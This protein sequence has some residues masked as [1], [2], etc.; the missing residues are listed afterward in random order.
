VREPEADESGPEDVGKLRKQ[1]RVVKRGYAPPDVSSELTLDTPSSTVT[2]LPVRGF[3]VDV[4]RNRQAAFRSGGYISPNAASDLQNALK[5]PTVVETVDSKGRKVVEVMASFEEGSPV[6]LTGSG[7]VGKFRLAK[8]LWE[9]LQAQRSLTVAEFKVFMGYVNAYPK[10]FAQSAVFANWGNPWISVLVTLAEEDAWNYVVSRAY[11]DALLGFAGFLWQRYIDGM[12]VAV[13]SSHFVQSWWR[14]L[15][16]NW[17]GRLMRPVPKVGVGNNIAQSEAFKIRLYDI[18][19][20]FSHALTTMQRLGVHSVG[21]T[22][23]LQRILP[24]HQRAPNKIHRLVE[25][26][27]AEALDVNYRMDDRWAFDK[28]KLLGRTD[29]GHRRGSSSGSIE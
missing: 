16:H 1:R 4:P 11:T 6:E 12:L 23:Q 29:R 13:N 17:G 8:F 21:G 26:G 15:I 25:T 20:G 9:A 3:A 10:E 27:R 24:I 5:S 7:G 2:A 14:S 19:A 28:S 22:T 18:R